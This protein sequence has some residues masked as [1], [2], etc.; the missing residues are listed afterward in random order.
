MPPIPKGLRPPA[1][2]CEARATLGAEQK[3]ITTLKGLRPPP[4]T[5]TPSPHDGGVGRGPRSGKTHENNCPPLPSPL[6]PRPEERE[7]TSGVRSFFASVS[8]PGFH[9][10]PLPR[11]RPLVAGRE[12]TV[13]LQQRTARRGS[14]SRHPTDQELFDQR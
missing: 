13:R 6:L 3:W 5:P 9:R 10:A 2:G 8:A 14:L 11:S 7:K 1:Q 4:I 12:A